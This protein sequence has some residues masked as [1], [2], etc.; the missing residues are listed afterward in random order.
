MTKPDYQTWRSNAYSKE[1]ELKCV[2]HFCKLAEL[3]NAALFPEESQSSSVDVW[4]ENGGRKYKIQVVEIAPK[5]PNV[6]KEFQDA[7]HVGVYGALD[8][9]VARVINAAIKDKENKNYT[10]A[11]ELNLLIYWTGPHEIPIIDLDED[12][13]FPLLQSSNNS[14]VFPTI[15]LL[16]ADHFL[17]LKGTSLFVRA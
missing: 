12:I 9:Q 3:H 7:I 17:Y 1:R 13:D 2:Q 4:L 6:L 11:N 8:A 10:D 15:I 5:D 16:T 14:S